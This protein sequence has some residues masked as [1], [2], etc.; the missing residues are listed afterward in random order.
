MVQGLRIRPEVQRTW[1][2]SL[3]RELTSHMSLGN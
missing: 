3:V 2:L 1:V